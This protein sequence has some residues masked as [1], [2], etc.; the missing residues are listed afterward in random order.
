[1]KGKKMNSIELGTY[2]SRKGTKVVKELIGK[3]TIRKTVYLPNTSPLKKAGVDGFYS[4]KGCPNN[5]LSPI[6]AFSFEKG[7]LT[8]GHIGVKNLIQTIKRFR[9]KV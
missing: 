7:I 6:T 2:V 8:Q 5:I 9:L 1:M 3:K 4:Y